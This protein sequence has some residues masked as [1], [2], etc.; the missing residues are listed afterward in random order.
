MLLQDDSCNS[1]FDWKQETAPVP[2]RLFFPIFV[3]ILKKSGDLSTNPLRS[4]VFI[5]QS[6]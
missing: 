6:F 5:F 2:R 3:S 1:V 4:P